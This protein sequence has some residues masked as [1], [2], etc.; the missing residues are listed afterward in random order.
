MNVRG[1]PGIRKWKYNQCPRARQYPRYRV[2]LIR[3]L[4]AFDL[5]ARQNRQ[6]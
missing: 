3:Y 2:R 5:F 1:W 6:Q 4:L